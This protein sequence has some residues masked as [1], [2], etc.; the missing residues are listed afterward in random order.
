MIMMT[1]GGSC[2]GLRY[3]DECSWVSSS[4]SRSPTAGS[5]APGTAGGHHHLIGYQFAAAGTDQVPALPIAAQ[6]GGR[7][8]FD[9]R[10]AEELREV[11][12]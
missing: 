12:I 2:S 11:W 9:D 1:P 8:T 3:C 6:P 10:R 5:T 7:D 4:G